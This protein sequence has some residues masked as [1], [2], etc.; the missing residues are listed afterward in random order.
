MKET[1]QNLKKVYEFGKKYKI[2][3]IFE[4]IGAINGIVIGIVLPLLAAKQIVNF[5]SS[6]WEQDLLEK[7][8]L[9]KLQ[10]L[11]CY[12]SFIM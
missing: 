9:G 4:I 2:N 10:Y 5:T 6:I 8:E 12:V 7:V 11:I 3:L 1:I